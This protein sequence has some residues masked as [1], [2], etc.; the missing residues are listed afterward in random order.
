MNIEYAKTAVK[1]LSRLD[2][3]TKER[4]RLAIEKLPEGNIKPIEG[5]KNPKFRMRMGDY[6]VLYSIHETTTRENGKETVTQ[7]VLIEEIGPR[8]DVYK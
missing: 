6:R 5:M 3:P 8:G 1:Y 4:L 2:R 7:T